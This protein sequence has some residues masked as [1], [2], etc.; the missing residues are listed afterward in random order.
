[1]HKLI[2]VL[3]LFLCSCQCP[4]ESD[5]PFIQVGI[6]DEAFQVADEGMALKI[7]ALPFAVAPD[8]TMTDAALVPDMVNRW[9]GWLTNAGYN[10]GIE[11]ADD[12]I[13]QVTVA[14][15]YVP[16]SGCDTAW[17]GERCRPTT[18]ATSHIRYAS[19]GTIIGGEIVI[20]SDYDYS[21]GRDLLVIAG[22][23]EL[24]HVVYALADDPGPP[25]TVELQSIMAKPY[26]PLGRPTKADIDRIAPFLPSY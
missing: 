14:L 10:P 19:D 9:R 8:W 21:T 26:D 18:L 24:G 16:N 20:S 13:Y 11:V 6:E 12:S 2:T 3:L 1:M 7:G 5:E 15:G 17:P 25:R 4:S 22:C 23:H